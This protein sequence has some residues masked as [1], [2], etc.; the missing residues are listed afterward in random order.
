MLNM[1]PFKVITENYAL[2]SFVKSLI[3]NMK[4]DENKEE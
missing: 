4:K 2:R 1:I 3:K